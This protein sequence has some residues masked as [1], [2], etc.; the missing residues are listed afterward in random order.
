MAKPAATAAIITAT[1]KIFCRRSRNAA[2]QK[3]A[4]TTAT[5]DKTGSRSAVK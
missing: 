2:A 3:P 5:A 4:A 1:G